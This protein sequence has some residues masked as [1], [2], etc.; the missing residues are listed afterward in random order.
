MHHSKALS[1]SAKEFETIGKGL[2]GETLDAV[3]ML[4]KLDRKLPASVLKSIEPSDADLFIKL[5]TEEL[6]EIVAINKLTDIDDAAKTLKIETILKAKGIKNMNKEVINV[7]KTA[8]DVS[9]L[10]SMVKILTKSK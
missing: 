5:G 2:D 10:K 6:D 9:E 7:L 1:K 3:A 4:A 8:E